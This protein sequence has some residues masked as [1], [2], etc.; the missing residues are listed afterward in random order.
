[1]SPQVFLQSAARNETFSADRAAERFLSRVNPHVSFKVVFVIESVPTLAAAK[2][3]V[4]RL[5]LGVLL[6]L[7]RLRLL[8][9]AL[10]TP[11]PRQPRELFVTD[12]A[13]ELFLSRVDGHVLCHV[14]F[15]SE[16]FA[17]EWASE[18]SLSCVESLVRPQ[19]DHAAKSFS[20]LRAA[21]RFL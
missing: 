2:R 7:V 13:A 9:A 19:I 1:M 15:L 14:N 17:T 6:G 12:A 16:T 18:R 4:A 5:R 20:A 21:E 8:A 11:E 3:F 10:V